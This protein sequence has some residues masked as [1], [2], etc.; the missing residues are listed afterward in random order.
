MLIAK[1]ARKVVKEKPLRIKFIIGSAI[2]AVFVTYFVCLFDVLSETGKLAANPITHIKMYL[3]GRTSFPFLSSILFSILG[4]ALVFLM[5]AKNVDIFERD[6]RNYSYSDSGVYGTAAPAKLEDIAEFASVAPIEEAKGMIV[7]QI[8]K[9][10]AR[11]V[12]FKIPR[13]ES[14]VK[15]VV[16]ML[17]KIRINKHVMIMGASGSGKSYGFA[18]TDVLQS[19]RRG[20][21]MILTDPKGELFTRT[22]NIARANGY[23]VKRYDLKDLARSDGWDCLREVYAHPGD[24]GADFQ[25]G[26]FSDAVIANVFD[27]GANIFKDGPRMLL[28]A[29]LLRVGLGDDFGTPE[30]PRTLGTCVK[31]LKSGETVLDQLFNPEIMAQPGCGG[32]AAMVAAP[33]YQSFKNASPPL[34]GNILIGLSAAL[35][36]LDIKV[37]QDVTGTNDIDLTLPA[38]EKCIYYCLLPDQHSSMTFLSALFFNFLFI[39]LVDYCN[40]QPDGKAKVPVNFLLDEFANIGTIPDFDQK[41][42]TVRSRDL[43]IRIIVQ[44]IAQLQNRYPRTYLTLMSN[45]A[46]HICLG[47]N[48]LDT[49]NYYSEI[50]GDATVKVKTEQHDVVDPMLAPGLRHSTGD[51][52]RKV[53]TK[54]ELMRMSMDECLV[55]FQYKNAMMLHKFG[56][57][58]HPMAKELT[59]TSVGTAPA[60]SDIAERNRVREMEAVRLRQF[61]IWEASGA[62]PETKPRVYSLDLIESGKVKLDDVLAAYH[63]KTQEV[64]NISFESWCA[65]PSLDVDIEDLPEMMDSEFAPI[66]SAHDEKQASESEPEQNH[67]PKQ[68]EKQTVNPTNKNESPSTAAGS[69]HEDTNPS[70]EKNYLPYEKQPRQSDPVAGATTT[71]GND[72][73]EKGFQELREHSGAPKKKDHAKKT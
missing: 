54:D 36:V 7:G 56:Y 32:E 18:T 62:D 39:D 71:L 10:E 65:E 8:T 21:S 14:K 20:E 61:R 57:P 37:V 16:Y 64:E 68:K 27:D 33:P 43:N 3:S 41:L 31:L 55:K 63:P 52:K 58:E 25:A 22:A 73:V 19:I 51:G 59:P 44:D 17:P 28:K 5:V 70:K 50:S 66:A 6:E 60:I 48:D 38:R 13:G 2:F 11:R 72:V 35:Q 12:G 40:K 4:T 23:I 49:A 34:R 29:L 69:G 15:H 67:A 47:I 46:V 30:S 42:A 9:R 53:Y 26:L 1:S 45:C 24:I